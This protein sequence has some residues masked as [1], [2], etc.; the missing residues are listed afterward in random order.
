MPRHPGRVGGRNRHTIKGV[1]RLQDGVPV[2]VYRYLPSGWNLDDP[3][4]PVHEGPVYHYTNLAGVHGLI[5]DNAAWASH[6]LDLNDPSERLFGWDVIRR[7]LK[8]HPPA[9]SEGALREL[10]KIVRAAVSPGGWYPQPFVLSASAASD[11]LTQYRL[12]G[13]C[14]VQLAGGTWTAASQ[15]DRIPNDLQAVWRPVLYGPKA[16]RRYVDRML[17]AAIAIM[18]AVPPED[19]TDEGLTAMLALEALALHIKDPAY[20]DEREVRLVFSAPQ[21]LSIGKTR[22]SGER[23]VTYL[24]AHPEGD[25]I[26]DVVRS[27]RLGPLAGS[28]RNIEAIRLHHRNCSREFAPT[29]VDRDAGLVVKRSR[30]RYTGN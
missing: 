2:A 9:G 25:G 14:Q 26:R 27:V 6:V 19:Y 4:P 21:Y 23:L 28:S 29:I 7:R 15:D 24:E 8:K 18:D 30:T 11:S 22:V 1:S 3:L 16:A 13:Q 17:R 20:A 5:K 10:K 12:Y